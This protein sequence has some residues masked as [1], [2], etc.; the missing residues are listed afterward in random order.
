L[1]PALSLFDSAFSGDSTRVN[2]HITNRQRFNDREMTARPQIVA[3]VSHFFEAAGA[4][5]PF[6]QT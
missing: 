4:N 2:Q 5:N 6:V 1:S 3:K